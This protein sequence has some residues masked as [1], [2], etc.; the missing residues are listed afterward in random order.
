MSGYSLLSL[1]A[2]WIAWSGLILVNECAGDVRDGDASDEQAQDEQAQDEQAQDEQAQDEFWEQRHNWARRAAANWGASEIRVSPAALRP[3]ANPID[4]FINQRLA[5]AD[6]QPA[7]SAED[8]MYFRRLSLDIRGRISTL[9]EVE[10]FLADERPDKRGRALD[11]MLASSDWAD[12]WVGYW[13]DVLAENPSLVYPTL[14]NSGPFRRWIYES[15][16]DNLPFDQFATELVLMDADRGDAGTQG[17]ALAAQNDAPMAMKA[18]I[19]VKAFLGIDLKCARCHDSPHD[20]FQQRDLFQI[21]ALLHE[22]PLKI[23]ATS[24]A[25]SQVTVRG[26]LAAVTTTLEP[27]EIVAPLWPPILHTA[28]LPR[29]PNRPERDRLVIE[30]RELMPIQPQRLRAQLAARLT[31]PHTSRFSD[32]AV[33]RIWK[34]FLG[35]GL[36]EPV[37]D[38]HDGATTSHPELLRFLS[39]YFVETGYDVK[40]LARLIVSSDC[41]QRSVAESYTGRTF[42]AQRLR[43]MSGEQLVDSLFVAVGKQFR[44]ETLALHATDPGAVDLPRPQRAWQFVALPNERDRPALGMPVSQTIVDVL[45]AFGWTGARQQPRSERESASTAIQPLILFHGLMSQRIVRLSDRSAITEL[46]LQDQTVRELVDQLFT[47][48]LSRRANDDERLQFVEMLSPGFDTRRT[49]SPQ[50]AVPPLSTF[51]PD[52][53]KH[54]EAEQTRLLLAAEKRVAQGEPPTARLTSDFRERVEDALWALINS[55][56][57]I[58]IP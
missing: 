18:H 16:R 35:A 4:S 26:R 56:E 25:A 10:V 15:F 52:W 1:T 50:Q 19:V 27:D 49:G 53:R 30:P 20:D 55:P 37:D 36:T 32:V 44:A 17:F 11:W 21:A 31:S 24:V 47:T 39:Y 41:Y 58:L 2:F 57:F 14:N 22:G 33:N 7:P 46:C 12:G 40:R 43:R 34:R 6:L 28:L 51:Q 48:V 29:H 23:P 54:L 8:A 42:A 3:A 9:Y 13:Q 5:A 45:A 38:W